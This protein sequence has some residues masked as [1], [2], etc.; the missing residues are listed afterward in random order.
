MSIGGGRVRSEL[1][2]DWWVLVVGRV[3]SGLVKDWWVLVVGGLEV[4][5]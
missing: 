5:W 4:G 3:R 1:A 2:K